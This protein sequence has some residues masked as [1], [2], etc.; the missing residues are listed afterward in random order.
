[1]RR[2]SSVSVLL[3]VALA[4]TTSAAVASEKPIRIVVPWTPGG[5]ND[6]LV[7]SIANSITENG[8]TVIVENRPG[9]S[10]AI[11]AMAVARAP[12]DG[13]TLFA[14]NADTHAINPQV[15]KKLAYD[16]VKDFEPVT[17]IA[18]VPFAL[19]TN[20]KRPDL[21]HVEGLVASAKSKP[22]TIT[23]A[24]WGTGSASHVGM[25]L[26]LQAKG[27]K[28]HHVP[29]P[30]QTPGLLAVQGGHVD[31]MLL[32]AGGAEAAAHGGTVNLLAVAAEQRLSLMPNAPTLKEEG[33]DLTIGN[34][35]AIHAPARTPAA[36]IQRSAKLIADALNDVKVIETYRL[37]A[38]VPDARGPEHLKNYVLAEQKRWEG[39]VRTAKI[40][41][42]Q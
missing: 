13:L 7:R 31:S 6:V 1:M 5:V 22:N 14:S 19:V 17:L 39:V 37:Q 32:P 11:G 23:F 30:S 42:D 33:T 41:I 3:S 26:F 18:R 28:M 27:I 36:A 40:S 2:T 9:A 38:A 15:F 25:E 35:F 4:L 29:Y 20:V 34:W 12:A 21:K 16:P 24:S 8:Q 10:G